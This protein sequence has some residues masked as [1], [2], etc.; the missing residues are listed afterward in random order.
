MAVLG[1]SQWCEREKGDSGPFFARMRA[2][3]V[4]SPPEWEV[5]AGEGVC[6]YT[7]EDGEGV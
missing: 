4:L 5:A 3:L 6:R 1:D 7:G 2:M